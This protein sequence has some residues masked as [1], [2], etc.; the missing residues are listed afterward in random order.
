M[1][2]ATDLPPM[3]RTA[4]AASL[5]PF[6]PTVLSETTGG[7]AERPAER[8]GG[9]PGLAQSPAGGVNS[10]WRRGQSSPASAGDHCQARAPALAAHPAVPSGLNLPP[11]EGDRDCRKLTHS[12]PLSI[13]LASGITVVISN[14]APPPSPPP[15]PTSPASSPSRPLPT[16]P[17]FCPQTPCTSSTGSTASC[18]GS[19][20]C[21]RLS[22]TS[23]ADSAPSPTSTPAPI[24]SALD[25]T[26]PS[27]ASA[28]PPTALPTSPS[29]SVLSK[30]T[31]MLT[32]P[33]SPKTL[34]SSTNALTASCWPSTASSP[35]E[36]LRLDNP[37]AS[38]LLVDQVQC[39]PRGQ[40]A[41][42]SRIAAQHPRHAP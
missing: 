5:M 12:W 8:A 34:P 9:P 31:Q 13:A 7:P 32:S 25:S 3:V 4:P 39:H 30:L 29:S 35:P 15:L 11:S 41:T 23:S 6:K 27:M 24:P 38:L 14:R 22:P 40:G 17:R 28:L 18:P 19:T 20:R 16:A 21:S 37:S 1:L 10:R 36:A 26:T 33:S 42:C 2:P